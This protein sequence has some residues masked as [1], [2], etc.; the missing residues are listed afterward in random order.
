MAKKKNN[1]VKLYS[2]DPRAGELYAAI[3]DL[4]AER[5]EGIPFATVVGVLE[6]AKMNLYIGQ[7]EAI[8]ERGY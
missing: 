3:L 5:S 6:M 8:E 7:V 1:V 2:G 4:V